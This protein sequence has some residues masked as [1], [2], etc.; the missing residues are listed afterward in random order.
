MQHAVIG[1]PAFTSVWTGS[2]VEVHWDGT[3]LLCLLYDG[4][5]SAR[6]DW[7]REKA[8]GRDETRVAAVDKTTMQMVEARIIDGRYKV[9]SRRSRRTSWEVREHG[10]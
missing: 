4:L 6:K 5:D 10:I 8:L 1:H 9:V 2:Q 7:V 3:E